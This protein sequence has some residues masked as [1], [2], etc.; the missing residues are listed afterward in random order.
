MN[1]LHDTHDEKKEKDLPHYE[2]TGTIL[3]KLIVMRY[4]RGK[5]AHREKLE[6]FN[7]SFV[8]KSSEHDRSQHLLAENPPLNVDFTTTKEIVIKE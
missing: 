7:K 8:V 3:P 1:D 5:L 2:L 4:L 6:A